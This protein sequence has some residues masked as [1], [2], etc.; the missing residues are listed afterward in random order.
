MY[1][2]YIYLYVWPTCVVG[3]Y[4]IHGSYGYSLFWGVPQN[5]TAGH[6]TLNTTRL[7][8]A[9]GA[10]RFVIHVLKGGF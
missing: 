1:V 3:K 2:W 6:I 9:V 8:D 4:T 10:A 7:Y 5:T